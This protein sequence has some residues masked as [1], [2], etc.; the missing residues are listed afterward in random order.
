MSINVKVY[1]Y[2]EKSHT[3]L[4]KHMRAVIDIIIESKT[5]IE[6]KSIYTQLKD[7]H[8]SIDLSTI[9]RILEKLH[10]IQ[11]IDAIYRE[12]ATSYELSSQF[13]PHHHHFTC[14]ECNAIIDIDECLIDP[15]LS[16]ISYI[17]KP[18]SHSFEIQGICKSCQ[19]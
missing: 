6:A 14:S 3:R 18:I 2:I 4:T 17:G 5:P 7:S 19:K 11:L 1:S 9:H 12:K 16:S 15:L 8:N 10:S 13:L